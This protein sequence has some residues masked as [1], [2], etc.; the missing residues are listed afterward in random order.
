M[1]QSSEGTLR[2]LSWLTPG[3][4]IV[5]AD[6]IPRTPGS[7]KNGYHPLANSIA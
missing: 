5:H 1:V 4:T 2:E 7:G 6:R 3:L